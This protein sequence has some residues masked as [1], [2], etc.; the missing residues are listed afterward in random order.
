MTDPLSAGARFN[1]HAAVGLARARLNALVDLPVAVVVFTVTYL[2]QVAAIR[3]TGIT[4][5]IAVSNLVSL[6]AATVHPISRAIPAYGMIIGSTFL[7]IAVT[8]SA[9]RN[10][11]KA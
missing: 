10:E 7:S 11:P 1:P 2:G 3:I 9:K 8:A 5:A 6:I 4:P